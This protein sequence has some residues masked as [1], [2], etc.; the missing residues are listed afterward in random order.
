[1]ITANIEVAVKASKLIMIV[2]PAFAHADIARKISPYLSNG[3]IVVLNPGRTFGAI[4]FCN[5]LNR[6]GCTAHVI[7]AETQTFIYASRSD[8]PAQAYIY[9]IKEALPLAALPASK[10]EFVLE[11]T[12]PYYPQFFDGETVLHTGMN[13]IGAVFHPAILLLNTG[14]IEATC[15][16]FQFYVDGVTPKVARIMEAI[17]RE[18]VQVAAALGIQA[19][20][21]CEWLKM[22]YGVDSCDLYEAIHNQK[23]YRGIIAP[24]TINHRYIDEDIPMS[25]VPMASLGKLL[26]VR[27][28]GMESLI[29]LA[30]IARNK[31]YWALGRTVEQLGLNHLSP[32]EML[33]MAY[34]EKP[35]KRVGEHEPWPYLSAN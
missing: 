12:R 14:W 33:A 27:V 7:V 2:V 9:S 3:Q 1:M 11:A 16:E 21:A 23:G 26:G 17:D 18:R 4:E 28:N 20:T 24:A 5:V 32:K 34:G 22:A 10:T 13:N 31:N 8:G 35:E 29:R 6:H 25:L 30:C 15:G 19:F